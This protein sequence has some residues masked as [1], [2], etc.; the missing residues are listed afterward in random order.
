MYKKKIIAFCGRARSGK[1]YLSQ[2]L[3]DKYN[4]KIFTVADNLKKLCCTLS[5]ITEITKLNEL[6]NNKTVLNIVPTDDWVWKIHNETGIS[7]DLIRHELVNIDTIKDVRHLLQF[8]GTNIIRKYYPDWHI[9]KL[10]SGI[11]NDDAKFITIDDVRFPNE[12]KAIKKLGG[13]AFFIIRTN[14][15]TGSMISNHES[16]TA[17]K[18]YD[19]NNE[20]IILNCNSEN[21]LKN[22][23]CVSY[24]NDFND[25]KVNGLFLSAHEDYLNNPLVIEDLKNR[26]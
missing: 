8:V 19:F 14:G 23:F 18:W 7:E 11:E 20:H 12:L 22:L 10:V 1:T 17:L 5:D 3:S 25:S 24:E 21:E 4:A 6:K 9:D 16:E 2:V 26:I 15:I 13:N